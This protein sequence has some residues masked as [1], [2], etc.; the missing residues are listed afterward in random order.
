[1]KPT[2]FLAAAAIAAPLFANPAAPVPLPPVLDPGLRPSIE[3]AQY[4]PYGNYRPPCYAVTPGPLRGAAR[5]AAGGAII[6]GIAGDAGKGAG[7]G[8]GIGLIG[9]AARR[10]TARRSGACY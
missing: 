1:M 8:A 10:A 6:G 7:I 9:S 5:G 3:H 2:L 4:N